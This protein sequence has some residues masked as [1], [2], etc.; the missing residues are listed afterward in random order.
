M[1]DGGAKPRMTRITPG[2][3]SERDLR[4]CL[5][6]FATGVALVTCDSEIGPLGITANS[7]A[8]VSLDPPLVLWSPARASRRFQ[9][10]AAAR[11]YAIHVLGDH[12]LDIARAFTHHGQRF[13]G[14]RW[15]L[16]SDRVP[17]VDGVLARF[18]CRQT[19]THDGGDHLIIVGEVKS[20]Q[21]GVGRPLI[22]S[23]GGYGGFSGL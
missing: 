15:S 9:A 7:F 13:D 19:A 16:S 8:S 23:G 12:Q 10:F 5:G 4:D 22:F 18:D 21:I 6:R 3:D 1:A 20:A 2:P 11:H 17:L 14:L